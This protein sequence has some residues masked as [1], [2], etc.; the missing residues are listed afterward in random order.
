MT[1]FRTFYFSFYPSCFVPPPSFYF[2]RKREGH[3]QK[4]EHTLGGYNRL[5]H[6]PLKKT[7]VK[8]LLVLAQTPTHPRGPPKMVYRWKLPVP[9]IYGPRKSRSNNSCQWRYPPVRLC[10]IKLLGKPW[11]VLP[12]PSFYLRFGDK[13]DSLTVINW[14][15]DR[16]TNVL[17]INNTNNSLID[18]VYSCQF[19]PASEWHSGEFWLNSVKSGLHE[20]RFQRDF[21]RTFYEHD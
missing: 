11:N 7:G 3:R 4:N 1:L 21:F 2:F 10:N 13:T 20:N 5:N 18:V 16:L 6:N 19:L 9:R 15:G 8:Q 17:F 12:F 14:S